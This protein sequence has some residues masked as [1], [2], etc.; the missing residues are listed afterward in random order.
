MTVRISAPNT[1]CIFCTMGSSAT[2]LVLEPGF[3][4][5]LPFVALLASPPLVILSFAGRPKVWLAATLAVL[6]G[7][8]PR[9]I[10]IVK[11]E[12]ATCTAGWLPSKN[13]RPLVKRLA[14]MGCPAASTAAVTAAP[15]PS[16]ESGA[17]GDA[18]PGVASAC[19][20]DSTSARTASGPAVSGRG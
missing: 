2:R 8:A 12:A 18:V 7:P 3:L 5:G 9:V 17:L 15:G 1:S 10:F 20:S 13:Q 19:A 16:G 6:R 11:S 4:A 14:A